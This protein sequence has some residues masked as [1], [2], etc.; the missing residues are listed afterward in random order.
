MKVIILNSNKYDDKSKNYGDCLII[1][2]NL[3]EAVVFDCGS[4][5]HAQNAIQVIKN[6]NVRKVVC[7][8]S[9]NDSDHYE[10]MKYLLSNMNIEKVYSLTALRYVDDLY[11]VCKHKY[12]RD[13]IKEKILYVYDNIKELSGYIEDIYDDDHNCK[14]NIIDGVDVVA[15]DYSYALTVIEKAINNNEP[16]SIDGDS[17]M[18]AA[19]VCVEAISGNNKLLLTGDSSF[20]NIKNHLHGV[21]II[22][23]PHHGR[24]QQAKEL[25]DYYDNHNEEPK[26]IISDNTG[27]GNG[28]VDLRLFQKRDRVCTREKCE[29]IEIDIDEYTNISGTFGNYD[30]FNRK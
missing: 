21:N 27:N 15:P 7:V 10:G 14:V 24:E 6:N 2:N 18:N 11:E 4:D 23:C 8:L 20:E 5:E 9:H 17:V 22:Q 25:F 19:S 12:S 29:N 1:I 13:A 28:G 3:Y 16:D 26:Y 30:I